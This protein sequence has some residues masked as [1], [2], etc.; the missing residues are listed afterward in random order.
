MFSLISH[1]LININEKENLMF[2]V[3]DHL[4]NVLCLSI[5]AIGH[6]STE[7]RV[8]LEV[9]PLDFSTISI[10]FCCFH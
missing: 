2:Y 9:H 6:L 3:L 7:I 8:I 5:G 1:V 10:R 4:L